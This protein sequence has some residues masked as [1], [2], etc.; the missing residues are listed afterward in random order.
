[1]GSKDRPKKIVKYLRILHIVQLNIF[2]SLDLYVLTDLTGPYFA[3]HLFLRLTW[4]A[5][6]IAIL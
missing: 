6:N 3:Q 1:M 5:R 4:P 2:V